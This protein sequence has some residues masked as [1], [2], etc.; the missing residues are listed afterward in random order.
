MVGGGD[1]NWKGDDPSVEVLSGEL[2]GMA[3]IIVGRGNG[4]LDLIWFVYWDWVISVLLLS[5][6]YI[7][8]VYG[9]YYHML[10]ILS[11]MVD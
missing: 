2:A 10:L 4:L 5:F 3:C 7:G 8:H 1:W 9:R 11:P 6:W